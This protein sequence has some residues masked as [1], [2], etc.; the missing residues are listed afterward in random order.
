[1]ASGTSKT[2]TITAN[3]GYVIE[4]VR[5]DGVNNSGAMTSGSYT[6]TNVTGNHSITATFKT[7]FANWIS[8]Y[9]VGTKTGQAGDADGDG[10][11]NLMEFALNGNP[12]NGADKGKVYSLISTSD[13]DTVNKA[14][15]LIIPVRAGTEFPVGVHVQTTATKDGVK[16]TIDGSTTLEDFNNKSWA[17]TAI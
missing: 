16:Y 5:V 3:D 8:H 4:Q 6:F 15:M 13:Y 7:I 10:Q 9:D 2:F 12:S 1:M 11:N 14:M 17:C